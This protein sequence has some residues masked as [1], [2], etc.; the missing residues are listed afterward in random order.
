M[1]ETKQ[2]RSYSRPVGMKAAKSRAAPAARGQNVP[3]SWW[4]WLILWLTTIV[5]IA[6]GLTRLDGLAIHQAPETLRVEWVD[7]PDW[8]QL[9]RQ[10]DPTGWGRIL[11]DL[12]NSLQLRNRKLYDAGLCSIVG[13]TL[14]RSA[15]IETL[16]RV[17]KTTDGV[18]HVHAGFRKPFAL[19]EKNGTAYLIDESATL[20]PRSY[21]AAEVNRKDWYVLMGAAAAPP[22][23]GS[24][25]PGNDIRDGLKLV[26]YLKAMIPSPAPPIRALITA[27]SVANWDGRK[28]IQSGQL[29]L[30]TKSPGV[31]IHW[32]LPPGEESGIEAT[33]ARKLAYLL[34]PETLQWIQEGRA[35]DLRDHDKVLPLHRPD[36]PIQ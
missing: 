31:S 19:I 20:L 7:L 33:A 6:W 8:L 27:I 21:S 17:T 29:R 12:E 28:Y 10:D 9:A 3:P 35:V 2:R 22:P 5:G 11:S 32:G 34:L 30:A 18:I 36:D 13:E 16:A 15:W 1:A 14:K 24:I 4:G 26:K 23:Q 25:W